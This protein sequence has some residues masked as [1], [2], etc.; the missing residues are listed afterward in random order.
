MCPHNAHS[1]GL[2]RRTS[3]ASDKRHA[4]PL[5]LAPDHPTLF[6][7]AVCRDHERAALGDA[8]GAVDVERRSGIRQVADGAVDPPAAELDRSGLQYAVTWCRS[9]VVPHL[10]LASDAHLA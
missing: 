10:V 1:P 6:A 4:D 3:S 5:L 9:L 8:N 7:Q 2:S